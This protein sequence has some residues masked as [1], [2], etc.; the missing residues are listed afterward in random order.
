M[1]H[2][3]TAVDKIKAQNW[4][5]KAPNG[6]LSNL[7]PEQYEQVRTPEFKKWF[8]DWENNPEKASKIVNENGEPHKITRLIKKSIDVVFQ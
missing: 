2:E 3:I 5:E 4:L 7:T 8:R 1:N 6:K